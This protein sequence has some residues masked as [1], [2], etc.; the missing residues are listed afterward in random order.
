MSVSLRS[1]VIRWTPPEDED[2]SVSVE[3][4]GVTPSGRADANTW[5][6]RLSLSFHGGTSNMCAGWCVDACFFRQNIGCEAVERLL[7]MAVVW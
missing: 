5:H 7:L 4:M 6:L 3:G 1:M 2:A